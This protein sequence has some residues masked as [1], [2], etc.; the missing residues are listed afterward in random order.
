MASGNRHGTKWQSGTGKA[1]SAGGGRQR[2]ASANVQYD[3]Y[4]NPL[5]DGFAYQPELDDFVY[6]GSDDSGYG[7][8]TD[9][10]AYAASLGQAQDDGYDY[11]YEGGGYQ[12]YPDRGGGTYD[13]RPREEQEPPKRRRHHHRGLIILLVIVAA[14]VGLY[15]VICSPVDQQLAFSDSEA[16]GLSSEESFHVVGMPYYV[17]ALGSDAREDDTVS[18]TDTM[19]LVRIDPIASKLSIVSIP[20]DLYVEDLSYNGQDYGEQKINAAY[21]FGGAALATKTV[22]ELT[23]VSISHVAVVHFDQLA[24]LIDA[25]GGITVDV[26]VD[27]ND[28]YYTGLVMSAG[29]YTMDGETA[30]LF[31]RVRHGFATGDFQRQADQQIVVK[32][33]LTR[34][35]SLSPT[36]LYGVVDE[37][38][39]VVST[40]MKLYEM[41]PLLLRFKLTTPTVY[42][43]SLPASDYNKGG[44]A[45]ELYDED[46]GKELLSAVDAGQDP[47]ASDANEAA[48]STGALSSSE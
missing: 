41:L 39:Q 12:Y 47:N 10:D 5:D 33:V 44:V 32:A 1:S 3:Q 13:A 43:C 27:V 6:D 19:M 18:R 8:P 42:S 15:V 25:I 40:D 17:L 7:T 22:A 29:T 26:P 28:P 38:G 4:G 46:A 45:Y 16:E 11:Q 24:A 36:E 35:L 2:N 37:L 9:P 20:R 14:I 21:A 31:A 23:G 34:M 30:V 48:A